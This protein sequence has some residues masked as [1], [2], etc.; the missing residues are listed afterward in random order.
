MVKT[1]HQFWK[2]KSFISLSSDIIL[3]DQESLKLLMK[4]KKSLPETLHLSEQCE[5]KKMAEEIHDPTGSR[6]SEIVTEFKI[7]HS[8]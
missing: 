8:K 5:R 6:V 4:Q 7:I 1:L 3:S 2:S